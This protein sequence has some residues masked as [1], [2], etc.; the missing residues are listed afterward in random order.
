MY[1]DY[2]LVAKPAVA[3][4]ET[5]PDIRGNQTRRGCDAVFKGKTLQ[6][7]SHECQ[8][9]EIELQDGLRSKPLRG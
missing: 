7:E 5:V 4:G 3:G 6:G 2:P 9:R 1:S 8:K